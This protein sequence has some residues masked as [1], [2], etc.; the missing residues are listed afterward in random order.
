MNGLFVDPDMSAATWFVAKASVLMA[1][2][3][4]VCLLIYRQASAAT[5]HLLWTLTVLSLLLLPLVTAMSPKWTIA[6]PLARAAS[7]SI[8][9]LRTPAVVSASPMASAA[10]GAP[11]DASSRAVPP[12]IG[13]VA[14][15]TQRTQSPW[16]A[17]FIALYSAG[18]LLL[19]GHIVA[20]RLAIRR[21]VRNADDVTDLEWRGL[22]LQCART[23]G[24]ERPVRLLRSREQSM[25]MA[26]GIRRPT[27]LVPAIAD[28]WPE[29]RRRAVLLH[30][31]AHVARHDC[32]TQLLAALACAL[33]LDP[34][35]CLVGGAASARRARA[36][37]RRSRPPGR[38]PGTRICRAP[39]GVG[40]R[41]R[42]PSR[43]R[44]RGHDGAATTTGGTNARSTSIPRGT[45]PS[46]GFRTA[47]RRF[48][49]P[50]SC[51]SLLPVQKRRSCRRIQTL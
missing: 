44:A 37:L 50:R 12:G 38:H 14:G 6:L 49:L 3:A 8:T 16:M 40:V 26:F 46:H 31:L 39:A 11:L 29:D 5:R 15:A 33:Y 24:V 47:S 28:T 30:E 19:L 48:P 2:A 42:R 51:L 9:V 21:F 10:L 4:I 25:P 17:L 22:F 45:A 35:G 34:P 41:T 20:E 23:M 27:I 18:A 36:R 13:S 1:A 43:A 32:L 7:P